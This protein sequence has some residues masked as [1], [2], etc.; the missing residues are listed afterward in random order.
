MTISLIVMVL[1]VIS[2][3]CAAFNFTP[4]KPWIVFG[5]LGMFLWSISILLS[6]VSK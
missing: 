5:W 3:G 1:A 4:P 2:L 6:V